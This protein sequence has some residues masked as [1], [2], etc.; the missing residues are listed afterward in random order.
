MKRRPRLLA[1]AAGLFAV[2]IAY[3]AFLAL[4]TSSPVVLSRPQF[5]V[6]DLWVIGHVD[7]FDN[8]P[9]IQV[10]EVVYARPGLDGDKP[11]KD[12]K[13]EV[14]NLS[15]CKAEGMKP[16]PYIMPLSREGQGFHV[17]P[18]PRSP[19][20]PVSAQ[21]RVYADTPETRA[22]LRHLPRQ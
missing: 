20:G 11:A 3:L 14:S 6:A 17:T 5:L 1:L 12:A 21:F 8:T 13:I 18:V 9:T 4:T 16:G 2:W 22:Q 19:G 10:N 15:R 7:D